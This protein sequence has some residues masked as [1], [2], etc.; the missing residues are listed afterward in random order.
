MKDGIKTDLQ[1][2]SFCII[3]N[4]DREEKMYIIEKPYVSEYL[5]DIIINKDWAVLDN[6]TIENCGLEEDVLN[7]LSSDEAKEHYIQQ[8]NPFIFSNSENAITWIVNNLP[9]SN[10]TKYIKTFKDKVLFRETLKDLY[11]DLYFTSLEYLDINYV[12]KEQYQFPIALKP[13]VGYLNFGVRIINSLDDWDPNIKRLHKEIATNKS[14]YD[15]SVVNTTYILIEQLITGEDLSVDAYYD[16]NGV[17]VILNIFK[18]IYKEDQPINEKLYITSA[19]TIE[20]HLQKVT[21]F[22]KEIGSRLDIKNFP[23]NLEVRLNE[24]GTLVP[25]EVNPMRF[26]NWC[27]S[28][29]AKYAWGF[30]IYDYFETQ[31]H[32]DWNSIIQNAGEQTY[33]ASLV[34]IPKGFPKSSVRDFNFNGYLENFSNVFEVRRV[35]FKANPL[36]GVVLGS[37]SDDEELDMILNMEQGAF[38]T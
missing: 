8:E 3:I 21:Q 7:L 31:K 20:K 15:E 1:S 27:V 25:I 33:Y 22:L 14:K 4:S 30:N 32:P 34:D 23:L 9:D 29:L 16:K 26:A 24:A 12:E 10:L 19:A 17:P 18:R 36:F 2:R 11:P 38:I 13:S 6:E 37:T 5:M 28:D 35:N